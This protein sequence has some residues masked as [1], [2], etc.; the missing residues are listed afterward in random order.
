M[1]STIIS[2]AL[3]VFLGTMLQLTISI[4]ESNCYALQFLLMALI[5]AIL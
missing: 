1:L 2:C 5:N 3:G 4:V